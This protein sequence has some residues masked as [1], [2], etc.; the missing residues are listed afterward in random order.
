VLKEI[1]IHNIV[2]IDQLK[3]DFLSE[4]NVGK[5]CVLTGETG[6]GKSILLDAL[7]LAIGYRSSNRL[8]RKGCE[9]GKVVAQFNI[10]NNAFCQEVLAINDLENE[11]NPN[12]LI[13]RRVL[14]EGSSK[15]FVNDVPV[16]VNLLHKIG[17]SLIEIHGQNEQSNL[18]DR[19]FHRIVLDSY[20]NQNEILLQ[21][22]GLFEE[23]EKV[24]KELQKLNDEKEKNER[25]KDYLQHIIKELETANVEVGE[26][27]IWVNK[28]NKI[29][30]S[31][32]ISA[33]INE[34]S[35][36][37]SEVDSKVFRASKALIRNQNLGNFLKDEENKLE[38]LIAIFDQISIQNEEAKS[39]INEIGDEIG[40][41]E[42]DLDE[43]EERLFLIRS[44]GRKF[45]CG[46]DELPEFL[47]KAE[48]KLQIVE[49]FTILA[50]DLEVEKTQLEEKYF[51]KAQK[52]RKYRIAAGERLTQKVENELKF[53]KMSAV[54]FAVQINQLSPENYNQNGIDEIK[55]AAATNASSNLD[56]ISKIASGGELSRFM[57]AL[58][59]ALLEVKSPPILIFDEIDSGIGGAVANAV[60]DRLKLLSKNSQIL[61]VTHHPQ[62]AAK[63]DFHLRV[64]KNTVEN[65]TK[66]KIE[67]LGLD[68]KK[69]EVA[70]MLSG[71][72]ISDEA[73]AAAEKLMFS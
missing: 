67:I 57:L 61:V 20:T 41:G 43:I 70:R 7:G 56:D 34:V 23:L 36:D 58:K 12:S 15:A 63:S 10:E 26:E 69:R 3:I 16:G 72:E 27:E 28:R 68:E 4:E 48:E 45:N 18:L 30:N 35:S 60:G 8:L 38:K 21:V 50:G 49:N 44:L 14:L 31:E 46:I 32:K 55:F 6:S 73:L 53:L 47:Q 65:V 22:K 2:L 71:E 42:D 51:T 62:I 39:L 33:I 54:R 66:T 17:A 25:E 1:S 5:F 19:S 37:V 59:V 40:T 9:K 52:L 29:L 13:L 11:E 64:E 24:K